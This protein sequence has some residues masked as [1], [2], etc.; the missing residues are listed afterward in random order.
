MGKYQPDW[1]IGMGGG[2]C[3]DAAK[4]I[5]CL[6]ARPDLEPEAVSYSRPTISEKKPG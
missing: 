5:I 3:I 2:S 4:A 1:V 6:L